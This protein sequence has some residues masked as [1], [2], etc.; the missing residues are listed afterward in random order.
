MAD[1]EQSWDFTGLRAMFLNGAVKRTP[2]VSNTKRHLNDQASTRMNILYSLQHL[3]HRG[4][5]C[6]SPR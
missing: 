3:G 2:E 5:S 1:T 4:T 6:I